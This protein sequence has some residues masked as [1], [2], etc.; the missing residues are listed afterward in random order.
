MGNW[1]QKYILDE[2]SNLAC[3]AANNHLMVIIIIIIIIITITI[4]IIIIINKLI[5]LRKIRRIIIIIKQG[6]DGSVFSL[7]FELYGLQVKSCNVKIL[8]KC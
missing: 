2:Y 5:N 1:R 3:E 8:V 4:I 6:N 7:V